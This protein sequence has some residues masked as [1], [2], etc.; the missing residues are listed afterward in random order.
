VLAGWMHGV[1]NSQGYGIWGLL[2]HN[3]NP[4]LGGATGLIGIIVWLAL[5]IWTARRP[6][7]VN[8]TTL[9]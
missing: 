8:L 2:F 4:L 6:A 5:G 9:V 7:R 3:V 1:L